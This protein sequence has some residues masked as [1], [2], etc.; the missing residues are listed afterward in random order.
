MQL[1]KYL[2]NFVFNWNWKLIDLV[3][4]LEKKSSCFSTASIKLK[5]NKKILWQL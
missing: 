5:K 4:S 3:L 1:V 2:F